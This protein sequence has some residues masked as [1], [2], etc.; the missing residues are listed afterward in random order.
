MIVFN[1]EPLGNGSELNPFY[2]MPV[3]VTIRRR[4]YGL[5]S[6]ISARQSCE[7]RLTTRI[8]TTNPR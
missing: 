2:L 7:F 8:L 5:P 3:A 1:S 4:Q 6:Y